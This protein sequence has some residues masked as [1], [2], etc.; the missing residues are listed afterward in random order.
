MRL[1]K[2]D[3]KSSFNASW[4]DFNVHVFSHKREDGASSQP[5]RQFTDSTCFFFFFFFL[6]CMLRHFVPLKISGLELFWYK[7]IFLCL[8]LLHVSVEMY[9]LVHLL[10]KRADLRHLSWQTWSAYISMS[11]SIVSKKTIRMWGRLHLLSIGTSK[12]APEL[13]VQ[14]HRATNEVYV[15]SAVKVHLRYIG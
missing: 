4:H 13:N 6:F 1:E 5:S 7:G 12:A 10:T 3:F 15:T 2:W 11:A 9:H 14:T 8:G